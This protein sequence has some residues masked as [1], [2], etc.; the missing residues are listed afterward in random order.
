MLEF[1]KF[2]NESIFNETKF[3]STWLKKEVA[4]QALDFVE[5][6]H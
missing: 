3:L 4:D 2:P 6:A 5:G 1:F